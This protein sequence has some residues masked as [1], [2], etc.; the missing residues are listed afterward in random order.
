M[1]V[2]IQLQKAQSQGESFGPY[3]TQSLCALLLNSVQSAS[4]RFPPLSRMLVRDFTEDSLYNPHYGYFSKK[5]P[6]FSLPPS[7]CPFNEIRD[8]CEFMIDWPPCMQNWKVNMQKQT[9]SRDRFGIPRR[10]YSSLL[11]ILHRKSTSWIA[12]YHLQELP[13]VYT[14]GKS[15]SFGFIDL[16]RWE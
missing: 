16:G 10:N 3:E 9:K 6:I 1:P 14:G 8:N 15:G 4:Y 7:R 13:L 12:S 5:K 2:G 11:R